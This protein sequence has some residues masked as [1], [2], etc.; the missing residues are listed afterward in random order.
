MSNNENFKPVAIGELL[1]GNYHFKIPSFQRGYRWDQK[2][3][4]DLIDDLKKFIDSRQK[5]YYLQPLVVRKTEE[6]HYEVLDGQQRL[7]TMLLLLHVLYEKMDEDNQDYYR[8]KLYNIIY[9]NRAEINFSNPQNIDP[10]LNID[11]FYVYLA[12]KRINASVKKMVGNDTKYRNGITNAIFHTNGSEP[13]VKFIWYV[14]DSPDDLYSIKVFNNLNKGKIS[15]TSSELIKALFILNRE[16][17]EHHKAKLTEEVLSEDPRLQKMNLEWDQIEKKF[18]DDEF[19]MF[20]S[21]NNPN[22]QTRIDIL[23]DFLTQKPIKNQDEDYSYRVFQKIFD[24]DDDDERIPQELKGIYDFDILWDKVKIVYYRMI[25]WYEDVSLYNYIGFLVKYDWTPYLIYA[26]IQE[27]KRS[28]EDWDNVKTVNKLKA[29]IKQSFDKQ[30]SLDAI[31]ELKYN[32]GQNDRY[33]LRMA[34]LLFNIESYNRAHIH[35]PFAKYNAEGWD[36]EHID[37]QTENNIVENDDRLRWLKF[38]IKALQMENYTIEGE[39]DYMKAAIELGNELY[40]N[41]KDTDDK[42][43]EF[44]R[45]IVAYYSDATVASVESDG[46]KHSIDNLALLDQSTNRSYHN[47]PYPYKRHCIIERDKLGK[48]VPMCTKNLFLKY[49]TSSDKASSQLKNMRWKNEDRKYYQKNI[50]EVLRTFFE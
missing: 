43:P 25:H 24:K 17:I 14:V 46:D 31:L 28:D 8:D 36:L 13:V 35:F 7:T 11:N 44:Y 50:C 34:L 39:Q 6:D 4:D 47:A 37:S 40:E 2:Q 49:Y 16:K 32:N 3:V 5:C 41:G 10:N 21:N 29:L 22:I 20:V 30:N 33:F 1:T 45:K 19:W 42:F 26:E 15:L 27:A 9:N 18:E 38:V 12:W 48:F 23:F